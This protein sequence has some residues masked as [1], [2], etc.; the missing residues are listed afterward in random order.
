MKLVW[1]F[2]D[3]PVGGQKYAGARLTAVPWG[4]RVAL[5]ITDPNGGVYTTAEGPYVWGPWA[6]VSEGRS[7]L[8]APVTAVPW[9]NRFA[10]FVAD[11]NGG[12][13]TAVGDPQAGF[14][15]WSSV[16][17]GRSTPGAPISAVRIP[18]SPDLLALFVTD[19]NG[20]IYASLGNP[21]QDWGP[22]SKVQVRSQFLPSIAPGSPDT[23]VLLRW[24]GP[25][26]RL[27][28]YVGLFFTDRNGAIV[29][30][31]SVPERTIRA[32]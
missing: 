30:I 2:A 20:V 6:G 19:T 5:F 4:E 13:C 3:A 32:R 7:T 14:G 18:W 16:S 27:K 17:D 24:K 10:L 26:E 28:D 31:W 29:A 11:P 22:W 15:P 9:G 21:D 1:Y 23:P 8:G 12:I 25:D